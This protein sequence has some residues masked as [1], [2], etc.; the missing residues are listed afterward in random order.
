MSDGNVTIDVTLT[1]EQFNK[2]LKELGY[3]LDKLSKHNSSILSNISKGFTALG[4]TFTSIGSTFKKASG[5]IIGGLAGITAG[6]GTAV[7]RYDTIKNFP[8]VMSNLGIE[9]EEAKK[10]I[11]QLSKGIDGLPTAL[12]D[13]VSGVSRLVAKN[14]DIDKSTKY[15]LAMNNAIVAR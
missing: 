10:S 7:S 5:I 9:S 15:F 3:D 2:A 4:N 11:D 8:K 13:A 1:K 6:L 14:Q 12:D